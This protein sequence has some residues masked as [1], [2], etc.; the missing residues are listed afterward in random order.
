M[1]LRVLLVGFAVA[2]TTSVGANESIAIRVSPSV[3]FAPANL[4]VR[5]IVDPDAANRAMEIVADSADFYR[6]SA[7]PLDGDHAPKTALFEFRSLPPGEYRVTAVVLGADGRRRGT[8][9]T[10]VKVV[11]AGTQD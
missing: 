8:A 9:S 1:S 3:S 4:T 2:A 10:Q 7:V 6:S 11:D 5:T